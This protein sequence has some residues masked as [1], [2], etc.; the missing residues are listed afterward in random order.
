MGTRAR[1]G[2]RTINGVDSIYTHWDGYPSHHGPIL[3]EHY[4][5]R[6]QVEALIALGD[7]SSLNAELGQQHPFDAPHDDPVSGCWCLAYGRDRGEEGCE[8]VTHSVGDW[9]DYGQEY[10]YLFSSDGKW[11]WRDLGFI[12][13]SD[14]EWMPNPSPEWRELNP[15]DCILS[16]V[17]PLVAL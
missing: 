16:D 15:A 10:E 8:A 7:L 13:G 6:G 9:P 17:D 2:L 4:S 1:I 12:K 5:E 3:L 14:G 11:M